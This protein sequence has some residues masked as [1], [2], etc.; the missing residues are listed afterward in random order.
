MQ[1]ICLTL[2]R[3]VTISAV[4]VFVF[5]VFVVVVGRSYRWSLLFEAKKKALIIKRTRREEAVD[6]DRRQ[7]ILLI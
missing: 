6:F 4:V 2:L 7:N 5:V 1:T 3:Y